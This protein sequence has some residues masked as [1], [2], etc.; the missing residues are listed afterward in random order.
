M[1]RSQGYLHHGRKSRHAQWGHCHPDGEP[2]GHGGLSE[3][4]HPGE[5]E[6]PS[7]PAESGG[8]QRSE[9]T[10]QRR[11]QAALLLRCALRLPGDFAGHPEDHHRGVP[12]KREGPDQHLRRQTRRDCARIQGD[13]EVQ[14]GGRSEPAE[15]PPPEQGDGEPL[16]A[17]RLQRHKYEHHRP[18]VPSERRH[19]R[20][21]CCLRKER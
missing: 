7:S 12:Q 15:A 19:T 16:E 1:K 8:G 11:L 5:N 20:V 10:S 14:G 21:I 13:G 3:K 4:P 17:V 9:E 2:A 6:C 18:A